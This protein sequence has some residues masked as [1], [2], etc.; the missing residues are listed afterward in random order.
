[1]LDRAT[2]EPD[3]EGAA[4][5]M[6]RMKELGV[7]VSTDGPHRNV[8]K[9]KPPI[10]FDASDAEELASVMDKAL[11]ELPPLVGNPRA[12]TP[13]ADPVAAMLARHGGGAAAT[14]PTPA[15]AALSAV[16]GLISR[17]R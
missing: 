15:D 8:L 6:G 1:M 16:S 7:L 9:M 10:C 14:P 12:A 3:T 11:S 2:K 4:V 17:H 5:V 13:P